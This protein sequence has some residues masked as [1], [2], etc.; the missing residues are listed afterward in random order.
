MA[1]LFVWWFSFL[2]VCPLDDHLSVWGSI[3]IIQSDSNPKGNL[4][5]QV[6]EKC[7]LDPGVQLLSLGVHLSPSGSYASFYV[8]FILRKA[9]FSHQAKMAIES[10]SF[11]VGLVKVSGRLS[12]AQVRSQVCPWTI[13]LS[14]RME[15]PDWP[16]VCHMAS[17]RARVR[18][19]PIAQHG[20]KLEKSRLCPLRAVFYFLVERVTSQLVSGLMSGLLQPRAEAGRPRNLL[21][22]NVNILL[23]CKRSGFGG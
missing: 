7:K 14:R 19:Q 13:T 18:C 21:L 12:S 4:W 3:N 2:C 5:A 8:G 22:N 11:S 16:D 20:Q 1:Y 17:P 23:E 10:A 6:T 9:L 15:C